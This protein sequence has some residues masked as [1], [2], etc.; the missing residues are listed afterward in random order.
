[1]RWP[2]SGESGVEATDIAPGRIVDTV[3]RVCQSTGGMIRS[4]GDVL[5]HSV[6]RGY[7]WPEKRRQVE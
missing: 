2:P 4:R 6:E 5:E 3:A 1:M 7:V